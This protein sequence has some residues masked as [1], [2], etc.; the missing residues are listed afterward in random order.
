M[1]VAEGTADGDAVAKTDVHTET[2]NRA[3]PV[4]IAA[5]APEQVDARAA[6]GLRLRLG[7]YAG[8]ELGG[9]LVGLLRPEVH[10]EHAIGAHDDLLR[11]GEAHARGTTLCAGNARDCSE[12]ATNSKN[13]EL[14]HGALTL[15][16]STPAENPTS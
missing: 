1:H 14:F 15:R 16:A 12:R 13:D 9:L 11:T 3:G 8:R 6:H 4:D 5:A 2:G 7:C 10:A